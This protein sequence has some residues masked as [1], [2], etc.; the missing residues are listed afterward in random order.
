M[1]VYLFCLQVDM[2][3]CFNVQIYM[4]ELVI[5]I[6]NTINMKYYLFDLGSLRETLS[7]FAKINHDLTTQLSIMIIGLMTQNLHAMYW[8]MSKMAD[9]SRSVNPRMH[10]GTP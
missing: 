4:P 2:L 9:Q 3:Y 1:C 6:Q 8:N 7:R 5:Q 10:Y